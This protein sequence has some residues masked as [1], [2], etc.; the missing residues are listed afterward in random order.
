[1]NSLG[2]TNDKQRLSDIIQQKLRGQMSDLCEVCKN[3]LTAN[4]LRVLDCKNPACKNIITDL[5]IRTD[6]YLCPDCQ[7]YFSRVLSLLDMKQIPYTVKNT[8]VRGLD[9]YTGTVFEFTTT[10]LGSQDALGAGGRYD[11]LVAMMGGQPTPACGFAFGME[12]LLLMLKTTIPLVKT[13][14]AFIAPLD[15]DSCTSAFTLLNVLRREAI[16][17][18]MDYSG[19]SLKSQLRYSQKIN[20]RVVII[21]GEEERVS[22]VYTVKNM[23][24]GEQIKVP[25][26]ELPAKIKEILVLC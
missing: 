20:A 12:R 3:R 7:D 6:D 8:L 23:T 2:C 4:P 15:A 21:I 16:A 13:P 17:A 25:I 18:D 9:Y 22:N 14:C 5:A 11:G 10:K 19:K 26:H 1:V 24:T